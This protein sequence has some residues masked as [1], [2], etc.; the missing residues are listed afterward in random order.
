MKKILFFF[1]LLS[2]TAVF[3]QEIS[4]VGYGNTVPSSGAVT[5]SYKV[6]YETDTN[7]AWIWDGTA[8]RR[9]ALVLPASATLDFPSTLGGASADL[10]ITVTGAVAGDQVILGVP[11]ASVVANSCFTAWVSASNTVTVRFNNYAAI[12]GDPASGTFNA[13]VVK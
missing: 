10:T 7:Y 5:T 11:N 1:T 9:A 13:K 3:G 12:S 2:C 8:F 6:F 4:Q